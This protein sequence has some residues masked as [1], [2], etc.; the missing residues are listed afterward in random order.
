M[1]NSKLIFDLLKSYKRIGMHPEQIRLRQRVDAR[2]AA[3]KQN[4]QLYERIP[5]TAR[6]PACASEATGPANGTL[7]EYSL[8]DD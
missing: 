6:S 2:L 8:V 4:G 3:L 5:A 7:A 1:D